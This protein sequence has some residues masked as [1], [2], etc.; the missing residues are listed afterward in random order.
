MQSNVVIMSSAI[1]EPPKLASIV[2]K[3]KD[4]THSTSRVCMHTNIV[5]NQRSFYG[6]DFVPLTKYENLRSE[7][8]KLEEESQR[9]MVV[10]TTVSMSLYRRATYG[11]SGG[12]R[13]R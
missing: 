10:M 2:N 5:N 9:R 3:M 12:T 7:K 8:K 1:P 13:R 6:D 4:A 11:E